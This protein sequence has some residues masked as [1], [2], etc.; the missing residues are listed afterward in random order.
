[1]ARSGQG[2]AFFFDP[3]LPWACRNF[4][5]SQALGKRSVGAHRWTLIAALPTGRR[6]LPKRQKQTALT[7]YPILLLGLEPKIVDTPI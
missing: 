2:G 3:Q 6:W 7:P 5:L 4:Q 1:M